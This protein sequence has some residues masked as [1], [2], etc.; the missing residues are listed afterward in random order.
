M[1]ELL[2]ALGPDALAPIETALRE[3]SGRR[4]WGHVVVHFERGRAVSVTLHESR[5][6]RARGPSNEPNEELID[7]AA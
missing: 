7:P 6:L 4:A 1:D 5:K 2:A 3:M